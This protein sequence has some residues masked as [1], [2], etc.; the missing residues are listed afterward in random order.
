MQMK[1]DAQK[2]YD[3]AMADA[4]QMRAAMEELTEKLLTA[5]QNGASEA[6]T[7]DILARRANLEGAAARLTEIAN[8]IFTEPRNWEDK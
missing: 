6:V 7:R 3:M 1:K 5:I 2:I 4:E 8:K